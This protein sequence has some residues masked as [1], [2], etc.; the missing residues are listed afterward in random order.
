MT[1]PKNLNSLLSDLQEQYKYELFLMAK[2]SK[3][4]PIFLGTCCISTLTGLD[5]FQVHYL[6][7]EVIE[8]ITN[9]LG[10]DEVINKNSSVS[11]LEIRQ[12][13]KQII[14]KSIEKNS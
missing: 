2:N 9:Y 12:V 11:L 10:Q 8:E 4:A 14:E 5:K 13:L 7:D 3:I 6:P 1:T